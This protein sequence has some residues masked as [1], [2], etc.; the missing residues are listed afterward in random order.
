M[1]GRNKK[2]EWVGEGGDRK[3]ERM[4]EWKESIMWKI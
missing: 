1:K 4:K 3:G 2:R